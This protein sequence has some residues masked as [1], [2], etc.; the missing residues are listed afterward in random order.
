[1]FEG[2]LPSPHDAI[3]SDLL[4]VLATWHAYAK[5]RLHT[6]HTLNSLEQ[7]TSAL[8]TVVRHFAKITSVFKTY[9]LP[10]KEAARGRRAAALSSKSGQKAKT[11]GAKQRYLNL[12]T[13]KFHR[14]G[15]YVQSIR[16]FGTSDNFT[17][18]VVGCQLH[19]SSLID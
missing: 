12:S 13:Y 7:A 14:L 11:S 4:F 15:D 16:R 17:T 5:L 19:R 9:D 18:Q 6:E 8:G 3:I 10:R 1:V 2:L